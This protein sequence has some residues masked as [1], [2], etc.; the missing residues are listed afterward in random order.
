[1]ATGKIKR[2][3]RD[4]AMADVAPA[5]DA[6]PVCPLC[7]RPIPP[8]ERDAHHLLP[9]SR[10]G[11]ETT[12]MHR[13]CHRQVHALFSETELARDYATAPAL[14][15]HPEVAK[16]VAWVQTKPPAFR[17]RARKSARRR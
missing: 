13:I 9:K 14:R 15:A 16:F 6:D 12:L 8:S 17:E 11:R 1:M 4:E 2:R 10:G 5:S 3:L 7:D